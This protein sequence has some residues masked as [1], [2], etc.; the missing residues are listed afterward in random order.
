MRSANCLGRSPG[1][2]R[3]RGRGRAGCRSPPRRRCRSRRGRRRTGR[4]SRSACRGPSSWSP[5]VVRHSVGAARCRGSARAAVVALTARPDRAC[6]RRRWDEVDVRTAPTLRVE[7]LGPLRVVVDGAAVEVRGP[8]RRAVLALLALA[9]GRTVTVDHLVDALWPSEAPESGRQALHTHVSRLR[10]HLGPA[11][12]RLQ[13]RPDGYRLDLAADDWTSRRRGAARRAARDGPGDA[14]RPAAAGARAV[15]RAGAGRPHRRRTD[16]RRRRGLR[17]AAPRG[18]RRADRR[19][20][21]RGPGGRRRRARRRGARRRS[22]ARARRAA[23][24]ARAGGDRAGRRR[25]CGRPGVPAPAGRRD[26]PRP[27]TRAGRAGTRRSRAGRPV[28]P[29]PRDRGRRPGSS[30]GKRRSRRCTGCSPAS[31]W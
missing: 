10:A 8:K 6:C 28:P 21:R 30:A 18:D 22:A 24:D 20:R 3:A 11:A 7:V 31:G 19:R 26:R 9:E 4:G 29:R 17:A 23:A 2:G 16:R 27:V 15:A 5:S 14:L 25:R 13:T 12:A 1:P